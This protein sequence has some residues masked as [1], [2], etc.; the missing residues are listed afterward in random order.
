M[1]LEKIEKIKLCDIGDVFRGKSL[2]GKLKSTGK[3]LYLTGKN[4]KDGVFI[5]HPNDKYIDVKDDEK[6]VLK[7]GDIVVSSLWNFRKIYQ[8]KKQ[9]PPLVCSNNMFIIR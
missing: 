8:Y 3:Y 1:S 7:P 5:S 2:F 6:H 9:D 4:I